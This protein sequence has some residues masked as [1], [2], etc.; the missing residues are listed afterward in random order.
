MEVR[1]YEFGESLAPKGVTYQAKGSYTRRHYDVGEFDIAVPAYEKYAYQLIPGRLINIDKTFWGVIENT[2]LTRGSGSSIRATGKCLKVWLDWRLTIPDNVGDFRAPAGYSSCMGKSETIMKY[3]IRQNMTSPAYEFRRIPGL[4]VAPD[5]GRGLIDDTY[6]SRFESVL[7]VEK[8][9]GE[10]AKLGYDIAFNGKSFLFDVL[11][12]DN[13]TASQNGFKPVIF[14]V[15]RGTLSSFQKINET[16]HTRTAFYCTRSGAEFDDEAFT[17]T[18]YFGSQTVG[19]GRKEKHLDISVTSEGE[20]Y[21]E[22][23]ELSRKSME[24]YKPTESFECDVTREGYEYQKDYNVG[25][26]VT[27]KDDLTGVQAD[28]Q[29]ISVTTSVSDAA[30]NYSVEFGDT[31]ITKMDIFRQNI[32]G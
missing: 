23:E 27:I 6:Y 13:R 12:G 4:E 16:G 9:L 5:R 7:D 17:Q 8:K 22:F 21:D 31:R 24:E 18:Y 32:G 14:S 2:N 29:I 19:L 10:R 28:R 30:V 11:E 20:Q 15:E 3:Y 26:T 25:D 1:I